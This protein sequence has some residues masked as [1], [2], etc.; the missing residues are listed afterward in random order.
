M[1][2]SSELQSEENKVSNEKNKKRKLKTPAQLKA[3]EDFYN[4]HEYPTEEMKLVLAEELGLTEKQI[5]GWFCHRRLE[6][7]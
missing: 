1:E 4:E 5:S 7:W 6:D 3:L 2:E